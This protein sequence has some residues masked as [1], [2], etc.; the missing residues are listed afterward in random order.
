MRVPKVPDLGDIAERVDNG[1]RLALVEHFPDLNAVQRM[2]LDLGTT[3]PELALERLED[4]RVEV[5]EAMKVVDT[6]EDRDLHKAIAT[7]LDRLDDLMAV[8]RER[9][10]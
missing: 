7:H 9:M 4:S 6:S 5:R 2:R 8:V 1:Q 10:S 3:R